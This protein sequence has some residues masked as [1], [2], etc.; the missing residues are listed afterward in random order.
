[1][2][3]AKEPKQEVAADQVEEEQEQKQAEAVEEKPT[4]SAH[5]QDFSQAAEPEKEA[6]EQPT[7]A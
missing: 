2:Y 7:Q 3:R 5:P 1:M 4:E 6:E